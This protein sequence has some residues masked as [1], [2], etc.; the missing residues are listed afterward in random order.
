MTPKLIQTCEDNGKLCIRLSGPLTVAFH[1]ILYPVFADVKEVKEVH[2]ELDE[3]SAIDLYFL[4]LV[5]AFVRSLKSGGCAVIITA[6]LLEAD[7]QILK[8]TGLLHLLTNT[9]TDN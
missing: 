3:P 7:S 5:Y 1:R 8:N 6:R 4:Q 9:S 2:V